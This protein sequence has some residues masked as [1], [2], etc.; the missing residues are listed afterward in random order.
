MSALIPAGIV[1]LLIALNGLFVAAEFAIVGAPRA[2]LERRA[3]EGNRAARVVAR[4]LND[5]RN[6]DRYIATAQLGITFATL[7]LGMYGEHQMAH[8]IAGQLDAWDSIPTWIAAHTLATI[9][10]ISVMT[11]LH[12]VLGEMVPKSLALQHAEGTAMRVT[13]VMLFIRRLMYPLVLGLNAIG[14]GLLRLAGID[15]AKGSGEQYYSAEEL[16]FV[17]QESLEGGLLQRGSG[18]ILRELFDLGSLTAEDV[19]TPRVQVHGVRVGA[20]PQEITTLVQDH[21]HTRYPVYGEDLDE[22]LGVVHISDLA[23]AVASGQ[24]LEQRVVR[25]AP[26]VPDSTRLANVV[27]R[28]RDQRVQFAVVLDEHGGTAGIITPDDVT[29]ELLGRVPESGAPSE[30]FVDAA[31]RLHVA[32]TIRLDELSERLGVVVEHEE[33][34]TVS[35]LV[36]AQLER[37]A[38]VGDIVEYDGVQLRVTVVDGHGVAEAV[39]EVIVPSE[40]EEV[41]E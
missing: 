25:E 40:D 27:R 26:F 30:M 31:S 36:L 16:E 20:T 6:Q 8:W 18:R 41:P 34:E 39:A 35:G 28:M 1:M 10:A 24:P 2:T 9:I 13:P 3:A 12:V 7:G 22:I 4:V 15:R 23:A 17:V 14:N 21:M 5:P 29:D 32:G 19:M 38:R 37:P 11:Y 33:V